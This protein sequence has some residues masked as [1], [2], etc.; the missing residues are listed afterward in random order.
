MP[1]L[2]PK[3]FNERFTIYVNCNGKPVERTL[4]EMTAAEVMAAIK[5]HH[6]TSQQLEAEALAAHEAVQTDHGERP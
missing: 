2:E 4:R 5:W 6:Q 3:V 1:V